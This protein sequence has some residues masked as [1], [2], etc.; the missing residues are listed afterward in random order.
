MSVERHEWEGIGYAPLIFGGDWQVALLNWE[1]PIDLATCRE[2]ERHVH[3]DEVFILLQGRAWLFARAG[4]SDDWQHEDLRPG[5][6]YNVPRGAWHNLL[7]TRDARLAIVERRGTHEDDTE[8]R[9]LT[10]AERDELFALRPD[11]LNENVLEMGI[12]GP[13]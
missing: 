13:S 10:A 8:I 9:P 11:W 6:L 1:P 12:G 5:R 4:A 2:I 7:A 3:T